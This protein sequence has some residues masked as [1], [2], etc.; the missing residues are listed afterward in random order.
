MATD[1][2]DHGDGTDAIM[3]GGVPIMVGA[4]HTSV[5]IIITGRSFIMVGIAHGD[6]TDAGAG[7]IAT[8]I[9]TMVGT[10]GNGYGA[11]VAD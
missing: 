9:V 2:T 7:V 1:G 4:D 3:A 8:G 10:A 6:G 5:A 11:S